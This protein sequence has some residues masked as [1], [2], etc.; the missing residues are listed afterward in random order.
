MVDLRLDFSE[1]LQKLEVS[2]RFPAFTTSMTGNFITRYKGRG[3]EFENFR[4]YDPSMDDASKIDWLASAK[5]DKILVREF[6]QEKDLVFF[7]MLDTSHTMFFS[8]NEYLKCEYGAYIAANLA[9]SIIEANYQVGLIMFG[10]NFYEVIHPDTG[11]GQFH[12]ITRSLSNPDY[13]GGEKRIDYVLNESMS[14]IRDRAVVFLISDFLQFDQKSTKFL[15]LLGERFEV[16]G[17]MV[18]DIRELELP[19]DTGHISLENPYNGEQIIVN[20]DEIREDYYEEMKEN[21]TF[22]KRLFLENDMEILIY[23]TN[24]D[25]TGSLNAFFNHG[26]K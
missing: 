4:E 19:K 16:T 26:E 8:S 3:V 9:F 1:M 7:I 25:L 2:T 5:T 17:I 11:T 20:A 12:K 15:Q 21:E 24:K 23:Y 13:Y 22:I 6:A 18:R 10:R 14:R